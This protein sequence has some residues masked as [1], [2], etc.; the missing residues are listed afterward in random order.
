MDAGAGGMSQSPED[1]I[2]VSPE[3]Q[4]KPQQQQKKKP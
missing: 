3:R 4:Q 2:T 1:R